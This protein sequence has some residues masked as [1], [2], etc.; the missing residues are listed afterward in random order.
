MKDRL[1]YRKAAGLKVQKGRPSIGTKPKRNELQRL[2]I[3]ES[4]SIREVA[5]ILGCSKD[6]VY[7]SLNEHAIERRPDNKRSKLRNYDKAFLKREI[8]QKGITQTAKELAVNISTLKK[9]IA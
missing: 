5:E 1:S 3:K 8:K 9:Y 6:M 7:R 2:Y 4:K